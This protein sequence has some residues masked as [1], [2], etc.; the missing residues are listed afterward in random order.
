M[1]R[2]TYHGITT[3]NE[4]YCFARTEVEWSRSFGKC[5]RQ[6]FSK[7]NTIECAKTLK[8]WGKKYGIEIPEE[9]LE[10]LKVND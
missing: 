10:K 6:D 9:D 4:N 8:R 7:H 5:K 3:I 1:S 2:A